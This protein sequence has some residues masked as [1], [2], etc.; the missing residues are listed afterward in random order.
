MDEVIFGFVR[1]AVV[2]DHL[3]TRQICILIVGH[4]LYLLGIELI[5]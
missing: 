2:E 1:S 3:T 5:N 4:V